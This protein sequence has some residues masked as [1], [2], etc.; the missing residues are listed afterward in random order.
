MLSM[1]GMEMAMNMVD[2]SLAGGAV[3][4]WW[5]IPVMLA[6]GFIAP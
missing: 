4:T 6:A 1:I 5:V 3:L 2:W